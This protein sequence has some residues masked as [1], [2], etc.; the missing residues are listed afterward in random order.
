MNTSHYDC[1]TQMIFKFWDFWTMMRLQC[2]TILAKIQKNPKSRVAY[3]LFG[4]LRSW[5]QIWIYFYD[6]T[7]PT[8][9]LPLH[10]NPN[11][12]N[13]IKNSSSMSF[14]MFS[15]AQNSKVELFFG[16]ELLLTN[17]LPKVELLDTRMP[18]DISFFMFFF[19]MLRS[20]MD[21]F[22]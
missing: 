6:L 22:F 9:P 12:V 8:F 5:V 19:E 16:Y 18:C 11:Y 2:P 4:F 17:P 14:V 15:M 7:P 3:R 21:S 1:V 10:G 20:N 13:E